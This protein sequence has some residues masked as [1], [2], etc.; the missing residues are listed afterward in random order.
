MPG[1]VPDSTD[2]KMNTHGPWSCQ[3]H[4]EHGGYISLDRHNKIPQTV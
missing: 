4:V 3:A 2:T 1:T